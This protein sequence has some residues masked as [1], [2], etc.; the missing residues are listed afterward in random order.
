MYYTFIAAEQSF[1]DTNFILLPGETSILAL[2]ATK[3]IRP[4]VRTE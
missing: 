3:H 4:G 1:N 2:Q